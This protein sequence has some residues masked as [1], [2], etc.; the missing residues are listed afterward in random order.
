MRTHILSIAV[1]F[2]ACLL[3]AS[4]VLAQDLVAVFFDQAGTQTNTWTNTDNQIVT[5]YLAILE[6]SDSRGIAGYS[7]TL[8]G[9]NGLTPLSYQ[10]ECHVSWIP[11][12]T[13]LVLCDNPIPAEALVIVAEFSVLVPTPSTVVDFYFSLGEGLQA[14]Y[15]PAGTEFGEMVFLTPVSGEYGLAVARINGEAPV[16]AMAHDWGSV[17]AMYR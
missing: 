2:A 4:G 9:T 14:H 7:G 3:F 8:L 13:V 11:P 6:P 1:I 12:P 17:K 15:N 16:P 10:T 5:G